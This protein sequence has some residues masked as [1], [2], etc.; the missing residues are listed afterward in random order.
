VSVDAE[1]RAVLLVEYQKAQDSA[2][3]HDRIV[4]NV[5][6]L[7]L[8]SAVLMG[9]VINALTSTDRRH[10]QSEAAQHKTPL[11][12]VI[13]LGIFLTLLVLSWAER[14][15]ALKEQK[16][17]RCKQIERELN[18]RQHLGVGEARG[19]QDWAYRFLLGIFLVAWVALLAAVLN[20]SVAAV[21][22]VAAVLAFVAWLTYWLGLA[23][24]LVLAARWLEHTKGWRWIQALKGRYGPPKR[25]ASPGSAR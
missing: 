5:T 18:M 17:D 12:L 3:H 21:E 8:G 11:V 24:W 1:R 22:G 19:W 20:R 15:S 7:W 23:Q 6:S 13:V 16:Y 9:F 14:A 2:E 25:A 10:H 4:G